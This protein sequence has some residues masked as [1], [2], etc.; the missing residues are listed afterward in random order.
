MEESRVAVAFDQSIFTR[1]Y[2]LRKLLSGMK[3]LR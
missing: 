2:F 1:P 3:I